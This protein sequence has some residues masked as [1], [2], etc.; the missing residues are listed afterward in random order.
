MGVN[1]ITQ[2]YMMNARMPS[3]L[4]AYDL[5]E[6]KWLSYCLEKDLN[7]DNARK[8]DILEF[9]SGVAAKGLSYTSVNT[10]RSSMSSCLPPINGVNV[11]K[12]YDV[13]ELLSGIRNT[14]PPMA[15]W[16][17]TWSV[18][19]VLDYLRELAPLSH[20][21]LRQ[22]S[23]KLVMLLLITSCQRVQTI[24]FL[25]L[26]LMIQGNEEIVFRLDKR[27]KYNTRGYLQILHLRNL[28]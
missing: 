18:D 3:T 4:K 16:N 7:H 22:L 20:L 26:S 19:V 23:Y 28:N 11:G 10:A 25:K 24:E 13:R 21:T 5:Q 14:D 17:A 8:K 2:D 15:R 27:L 6:R 1:K 12:D 9:L